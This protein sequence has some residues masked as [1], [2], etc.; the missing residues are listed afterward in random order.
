M[1]IETKFDVSE[2]LVHLIHNNKITTGMIRKIRI[3]LSKNEISIEYEVRSHNEDL[4]LSEISIFK[5][6]ED[7]INSL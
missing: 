4:R 1:K 6:R 3:F 2:N 5:T 7:L